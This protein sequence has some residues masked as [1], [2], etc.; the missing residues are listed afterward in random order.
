MP[1]VAE[2]TLARTTVPYVGPLANGALCDHTSDTG[3]H[4]GLLHPT[5]FS[6]HGIIVFSGK[7]KNPRPLVNHA[8]PSPTRV[9]A[10]MMNGIAPSDCG[11]L[12]F[13]PITIYY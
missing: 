13:S 10:S 9:M 4:V 1:R 8:F 6:V 3:C 5:Y 7:P 12:F 11:P 2:Q